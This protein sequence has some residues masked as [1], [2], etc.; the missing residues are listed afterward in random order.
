MT[1]GTDMK[2]TI[3]AV[4]TL[5]VVTLV[6]CGGMGPTTFVHP[7]YNFAYTEKVAVVPFENLSDDQGAGARSTRLFVAELLTA[8]A[9]DVVEPGEVGLALSRLNLVRTGDLTVE[10]AKQ[11]GRELEVQSV[12]LGSVGESSIIRESGSMKCV[13][14]LSV[15]MV[16]TDSGLTVWSTTHTEDSRGFWSSLFGTS[17][18][19]AGEVMRRCVKRCVSGLFQ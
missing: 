3:W 9:F 4:I 19:S 2:R 14:T 17:G 6:G 12:F 8:G 13:V 15:R 10:Q 5:A 18:P 16:E 7:D 1:R 11:L